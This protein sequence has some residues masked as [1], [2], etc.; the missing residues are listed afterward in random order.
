MT[1]N[2][3]RGTTGDNAFCRSA[4]SQKRGR[5]KVTH[6]PQHLPGFENGRID[7]VVLGEIIGWRWWKVIDGGLF[8]LAAG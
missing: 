2:T 5:E 6:P 8:R 1:A 7:Q 3:F 4:G